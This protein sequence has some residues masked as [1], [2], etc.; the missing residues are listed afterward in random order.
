[1]KVFGSYLCKSL[2]VLAG[3]RGWGSSA[4]G[5]Q[6][7]VTLS[8]RRRHLLANYGPLRSTVIRTIAV[9]PL[10]MKC[11]RLVLRVFW[12]VALD[13]A[14]VQDGRRKE[15]VHTERVSIVD[16]HPHASYKCHTWFASET[17]CFWSRRVRFQREVA[18]R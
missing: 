10:Y 5:N 11:H 16:E 18:T 1:M 6:H 14:A 3:R 17:A 8:Y 12:N 15:V 9:I 2:P 13:L 4:Y 7:L